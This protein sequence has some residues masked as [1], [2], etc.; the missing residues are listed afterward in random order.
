MKCRLD[1]LLADNGFGTRREIK[2]LLRTG[3]LEVNGTV[4]VDPGF[5]VNAE[6]DVFLLDGEPFTPRSGA[7]LMLHKP[8]GVIT[9]TA[10]PDHATVMDLIREPW[11]RLNLFPVGRLDAD[12]EGL[13]L[14][15]DDGALAHKLTSPKTG[16]DKTYRVRLR[17]PLDQATFESYRSLFSSGVTLRDGYTTLPASLSLPRAL[18]HRASAGLFV[19]ADCRA[20]SVGCFTAATEFPADVVELTIQEGKYHQVKRMFGALGNVVVALSRVSMGPLALDPALAPGQYRPLTDSEIIA[21]REAVSR[22]AT[23]SADIASRADTC[24]DNCAPPLDVEMHEL[25]G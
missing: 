23:A 4:R 10:D 22:E 21:L 25:K 14:I 20:P 12:T 18:G 1:K 5:V 7:Y 16:V 3:C 2:R 19:P 8:S 11:D 13:L 9:S 15:T 24:L 17:D 6:A